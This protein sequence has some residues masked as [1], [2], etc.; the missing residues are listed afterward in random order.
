MSSVISNGFLVHKWVLNIAIWVWHMLVIP[1]FGMLRQESL[2]RA[3][4]MND[5]G[6]A[7]TD[8][9][10]PWRCQTRVGVKFHIYLYIS[11]DTFKSTLWLLG[12]SVEKESGARA[13]GYWKPSE[14]PAPL[15][16]MQLLAGSL[17]DS[18][19]FD[20]WQAVQNSQSRGSERPRGGAV[21]V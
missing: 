15:Q 9:E 13:C 11:I 20:A 18:Q 2:L 1:A 12:S 10:K 16:P 7:S 5:C 21:A 17:D 3:A 6:G 19:T 4:E 8:H 14:A